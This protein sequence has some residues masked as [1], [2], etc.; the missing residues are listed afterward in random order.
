MTALALLLVL[1]AAALHATW[2]YCA[3][4]AGGGLPFVY[5]VSLIVCGLY[6]PVVATYWF[7]E[8]P[9]LP[10]GAV[11]WILGSGMLKTGYALALQR[12]Y[13]SGDFSLIYPLSRGTAPLLA[14]LGAVVFLD[15]RPSPLAIAGG[16][17][18]VASIFFLTGG[19][20]VLRQ[21]LAHVH[22]AIRYGLLSGLFIAAYTVWDSRGVATLAIA[23]VLYDAGTNLTQ[24]ALMTP[25]AW[26]RRAEVVREWRENLRWAMGVA[27][28][29]PLAYVLVL[30]AMTF[31]PVSYIAPLREVSIIFGAF[32]GA[33][34]L[35]EFEGRKRVVAAI[36]MAGG[37]LALALG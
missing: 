5:L 1:V 34:V 14:T 35:K 15:E 7:L 26:R 16:M 25:A 19:T 4:R 28:L 29:S 9:I 22:T 11:L 17:V 13:R 24:L 31:T 3:K 36:A 32:I 10:A 12:A 33:T 20:S 23:P 21:G 27:L 37:V 18:I 8:P 6:V 30:S 2:N